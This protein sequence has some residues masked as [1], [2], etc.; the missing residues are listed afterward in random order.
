MNLCGVIG[1]S[2]TVPLVSASI[3]L[4]GDGVSEKVMETLQ[5][6]CAVVELNADRYDVILPQDIVCDLQALPSVNVLRVPIMC[7]QC[8]G[9]VMTEKDDGV[10][11]EVDEGDVKVDVCDNGESDD[12]VCSSD[13]VNEICDMRHSESLI[14]DPRLMIQV[15]LIV[16]NRQRFVKVVS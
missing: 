12:G 11:C 8:A 6:T 2:I 15:S 14:S 10:V 1:K 9:A 13:I 7:A 16:G 4:V 5:L 3:K